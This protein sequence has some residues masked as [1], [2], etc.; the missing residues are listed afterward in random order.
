MAQ[1]KG[2]FRLVAGIWVAVVTGLAP[3]VGQGQQSLQGLGLEM[4]LSLVGAYVAPTYRLSPNAALRAPIYFG[5]ITGAHKYEGNAIDGKVTADSY[6][7]IADYHLRGGG[8]RLST[9]IG[10][11][12]LTVTGTATNPSFNGN[13]YTGVSNVTVKQT[14][15]V[16][17]SFS[18]GYTAFTNSGIGFT[19]DL[20]LRLTSYTMTATDS[21]LPAGDRAQFQAD[22]AKANADLAKN[23]LT[24]YLSLGLAYRF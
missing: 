3:Q 5:S 22:V 24:P 18:L 8:L 13:T 16:T 10:F 14:N 4:G 12:G 20:G 17:P 2:V 11:G 19:A 7:L 21:F 15:A 23:N 1:K 9:G 6:A